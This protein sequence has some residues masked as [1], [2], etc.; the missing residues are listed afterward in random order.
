MAVNGYIVRLHP[1]PSKLLILSS[2]N[3]FVHIALRFRFLGSR[4]FV[5]NLTVI[6]VQHVTNLVTCCSLRSCWLSYSRLPYWLIQ[7]ARWNALD[8]SCVSSLYLASNLSSI[9]TP[10]KSLLFSSVLFVSL[11]LDWVRVKYD[12]LLILLS[13]GLLL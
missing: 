2:H 8:V 6:T 3:F 11:D 7:D 12:F 9:L 5:I 1:S 4:L 13:L 10:V